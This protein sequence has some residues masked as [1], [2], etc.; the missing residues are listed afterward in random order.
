MLSLMKDMASKPNLC[1]SEPR[2]EEMLSFMK[3]K[4]GKAI[5]QKMKEDSQ[6]RREQQAGRRRPGEDGAK[7]LCFS[8]WKEE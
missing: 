4:A 2:Y 7:I 1:R 3:E 6:C 5:K 8:G